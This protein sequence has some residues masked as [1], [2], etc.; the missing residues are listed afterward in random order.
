M[1]ARAPAAPTRGR[2]AAWKKWD[3][4]FRYTA[5]E[6]AYF[7]GETRGLSVAGADV[8]DIGFGSGAFLAWAR[9]QGARI[10]GVEIDPLLQEAAQRENIELLPARLGEAAEEHPGR[11]DTIVAFDVLEHLTREEL[12]AALGAASLL[13]KP[14]GRLALRFPNGQSPF[15]L[16]PQYGDPTHRLALSRPVIEYYLHG[17]PFEVVRYCGVYRIGGGGLRRRLG[18]AA[19][20]LLQDAIAHVLRAV[21]MQDIPF[22]PVVML[23]LSRAAAPESSERELSR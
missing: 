17:A 23:I 3:R 6:A 4:L 12:I 9:D 15:G 11:F 21:Y 18:R 5:D 19:R 8:L 1:R 16:A 2:Y 20:G 22:D 14:G 7:R 10:A 13:L